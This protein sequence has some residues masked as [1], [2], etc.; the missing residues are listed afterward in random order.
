MSTMRKQLILALLSAWC[1]PAQPAVVQ[2]LT[3]LPAYPHLS[4]AAMDDTFRVEALGRWCARFSG[5]TDDSL[6]T[7]ENWY[8]SNLRRSSETDLADDR[9]FRRDNLL[10][11]V[12]LA[13][14]YDYVALYRISSQ[15]TVIE[16]HRCSW[17]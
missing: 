10:Y 12:K 5:V 13:V 8:R 7:V 15:R 4:V 6:A 9:L 3:G 16:L 1:L 11:G 17:N 14:D 2:N